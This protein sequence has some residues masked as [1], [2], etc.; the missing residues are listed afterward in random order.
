MLDAFGKR[1]EL[2]QE[3]NR[4]ANEV[5]EHLSKVKQAFDILAAKHVEYTKLIDDDNNL[6]TEE[7]W[8]DNCQNDFIEQDIGAKLYIEL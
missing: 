1:M 3:S 8:S 7:Q 6:E 4:P 2:L 5:S